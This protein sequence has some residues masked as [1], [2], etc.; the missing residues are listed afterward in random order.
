MENVLAFEVEAFGLWFRWQDHSLE[1]TFPHKWKLSLGHWPLLKKCWNQAECMQVFELTCLGRR[2][3][4]NYW[5]KMLAT[6]GLTNGPKEYRWLKK[7]DHPLE[8]NTRRSLSSLSIFFL[9][10]PL[11]TPWRSFSSKPYLQTMT[12]T[13]SYLRGFDRPW[14]VLSTRMFSRANPNR[15]TNSYGAAIS[16][17]IWPH[18]VTT[19]FTD[20]IR[21][22]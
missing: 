19:R 13:I 14:T 21:S 9:A 11:F 16:F 15:T 20:I 5:C 7:I 4:C 10:A 18:W 3:C 22:N 12:I 8:L 17:A 1:K 2:E 6:D